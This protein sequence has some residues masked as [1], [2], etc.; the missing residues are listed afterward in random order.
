MV[1]LLCGCKSIRE[2]IAFPKTQSGADPMTGAPSAAAPEQL[3]ELHVINK[4]QPE[5][6]GTAKGSAS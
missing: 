1:M 5:K 6:V 2:V 3:K 4:Q